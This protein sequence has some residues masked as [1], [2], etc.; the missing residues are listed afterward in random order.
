MVV[1]RDRKRQANIGGGRK[2]PVQLKLSLVEKTALKV[3]ADELG[4]S[5]QRLLVESTLSLFQGETLTE[6]RDLLTALLQLQR[7]L[8]AVGNNINQIA[9]AANATGEIK[10]D[11]DAALAQLRASVARIDET[12]ESLK[13]V[14][15]PS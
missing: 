3:H 15:E 6:R 7:G 1:G 5:I 9:R 8:A 13:V 2:H 14:G 12:L 11:L 4:V 10:G